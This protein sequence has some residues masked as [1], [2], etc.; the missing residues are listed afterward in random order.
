LH[1][2]SRIIAATAVM[3][4]VRALYLYPADNYHRLTWPTFTRAKRSR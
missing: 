4:F 3:G 1:S 2:S